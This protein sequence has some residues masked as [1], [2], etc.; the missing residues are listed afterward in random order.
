MLGRQHVLF[1]CLDTS[2]AIFPDFSLLRKSISKSQELFLRK[3]VAQKLQSVAPAFGNCMFED[4]R[5][6]R[7]TLQIHTFQKSHTF[8]LTVAS[9]LEGLSELAEPSSSA[10]DT[11]DAKRN[12][13]ANTRSQ[14]V[15]DERV[16]VLSSW[17]KFANF[18]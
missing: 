14:N 12:V 13:L 18:P 15:W 10:P 9:C 4:L 16:P 1:S 17:Q 11:D 8:R 5:V 6:K 7:K 3:H 2:L